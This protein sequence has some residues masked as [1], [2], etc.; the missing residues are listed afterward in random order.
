MKLFIFA[1]T[2][3][4][5]VFC[6]NSVCGQDKLR[7]YE[8]PTKYVSLMLVFDAN[9][10]IK[11]EDPKV[12]KYEKGGIE[13]NYTIRNTSDKS[14]VSFQIKKISWIFNEESVDNISAKNGTSLLPYQSLST[15]TSKGEIEI[16]EYDDSLPSKLGFEDSA[17]IIWI[18]MV[19]E[20]K[21]ADGT[22]Y[23]SKEKYETVKKFV[24][25]LGINGG[26]TNLII[27][28]KE[29]ELQ[30]FITKTIAN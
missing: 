19:T 1:I 12:I 17:R 18:A 2:L 4:I 26:M 9:C 8:I 27:N 24:E 29:L 23:N 6:T 5:S 14:I 10:P 30:N 21:L 11:L 28:S 13:K 20:V 16:L 15:L 22:I 25:S 3:L 7:A